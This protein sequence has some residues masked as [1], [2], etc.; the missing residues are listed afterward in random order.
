MNFKVH[1]H[2]GIGE[3]ITQAAKSLHTSRNALINEILTEWLANQ[4]KN[5]TKSIDPSTIRDLPDSKPLRDPLTGS[6]TE[7]P[8]A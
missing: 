5:P 2:N 1:L 7:D 8:I 6:I 3:K 4:A